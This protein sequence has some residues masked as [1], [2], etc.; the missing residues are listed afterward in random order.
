MG[1]ALLLAS[2]QDPEYVSI[3]T[4]RQ[5]ITSLTATFTDPGSSPKRATILPRI[6]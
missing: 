6:I 4:S 3:D 1:L 5:G 2:C